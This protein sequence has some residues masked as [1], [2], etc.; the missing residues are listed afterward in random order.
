MKVYSANDGEKFDL[1]ATFVGMPVYPWKRI[2]FVFPS[3]ISCDRLQLEFATVTKQTVY[4]L[5]QNPVCAGLY[6]IRH[7]PPET[8]T[9]PPSSTPTKVPTSNQNHSKAQFASRTR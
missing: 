1:N 4:G 2:Q 3:P 9:L 5:G 8:P 6:L 7:L